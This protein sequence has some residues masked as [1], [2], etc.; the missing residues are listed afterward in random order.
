M[1]VMYAFVGCM[2]CNVLPCALMVC[3]YAYRSVLQEM[4][5]FTQVMECVHACQY[6]CMYSG[7]GVF[8]AL[9]GCTDAMI[10]HACMRVCI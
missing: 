9:H 1:R 4:Q 7:A 5:V 2:F 3:M 10:A 6:P 8:E